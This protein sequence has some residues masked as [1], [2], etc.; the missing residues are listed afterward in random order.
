MGGLGLA[1]DPKG[2]AERARTVN[3]VE[4]LVSCVGRERSCSEVEYDRIGG[5]G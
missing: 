2:V 4:R 3:K 1:Q 5:I